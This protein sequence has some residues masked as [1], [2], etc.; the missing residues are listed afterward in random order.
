LELVD[1]YQEF[2]LER[3]W[4]MRLEDILML[5]IVKEALIEVFGGG[6]CSDVLWK[7]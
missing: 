2:H 3:S 7:V 5:V 6:K 1:D 4:S